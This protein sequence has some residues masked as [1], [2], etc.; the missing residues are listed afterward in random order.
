MIRVKWELEEAV[1]LCDLYIKSDCLLK[2]AKRKFKDLSVVLNKRAK[3]NGIVVDEKFRNVSGI[4]KQIGCIHYVATGGTEGFSNVSKIFYE[5]Y[6][7]FKN[8]PL[9][10]NSIVE[11]FYKKY[12]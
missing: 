10:F 1:V 5:A 2:K 9:E 6:E 8:N 4:S 12:D 7:L 11:E 3:I